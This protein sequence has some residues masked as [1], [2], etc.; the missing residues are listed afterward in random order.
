MA[1]I[2]RGAA[3]KTLVDHVVV[4]VSWLVLA[5]NVVVAALAVTSDCA[6]LMGGLL[7]LGVAAVF[8]VGAT[9]PAL[10]RRLVGPFPAGV[11]RSLAIA[12]ISCALGAAL[13]S[14]LPDSSRMGHC[15]A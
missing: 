7:W 11:L 8:A 14:V 1:R 13:L 5:G 12:A 6:A 10:L 3:T 4:L 2:A 15:I 9:L